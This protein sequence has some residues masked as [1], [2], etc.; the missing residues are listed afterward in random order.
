M[1]IIFNYCDQ[2]GR[3]MPSK[4]MTECPYCGTLLTTP[5]SRTPDK[6][7]EKK[8]FFNRSWDIIKELK[9]LQKSAQELFAN[10]TLDEKTKINRLINLTGISCGIIAL[11]PIPIA[12]I[13]II[14]PIQCV[15]VLYIG[16]IKGEKINLVQAQKILVEIMAVI[17]MG[18]AGQQA[19][20]A[21]YK[22]FIPYAGGMFTVPLVW[23]VTYAIGNVVVKYYDLKKEGHWD[24]KA[25]QLLQKY[26]QDQLEKLKKEKKDEIENKEKEVEKIKSD[27]SIAEEEWIKLSEEEINKNSEKY[28]K[29]I[30]KIK[31]EFKEK[32]NIKVKN[33]I[34]DFQKLLTN[35]KLYEKAIEDLKDIIDD[36]IKF[37]IVRKSILTYDRDSQKTHPGMNIQKYQPSQRCQEIRASEK[38]RFYVDPLRKLIVRIDTEHQH[39]RISNWFKQ[40]P[41]F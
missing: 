41:D 6:K 34:E 4:D 19:I 10:N 38:I 1:N 27:K 15:M 9:K 23:A 32:E 36:K 37:D 21:G 11:Q 40:H 16:K 33:K 17:G 7:Q 25:K 14:T 35:F 3:K 18:V 24:E 39:E 31:T 8:G 2:C 22:T 28:E 5:V 20:I 13:F 29:E 12:D 30:E 26:F